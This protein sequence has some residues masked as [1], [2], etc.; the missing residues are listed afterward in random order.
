MRTLLKEDGSMDQDSGI[1]DGDKWV[2]TNFI[3]LVT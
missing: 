2:K 3:D 1:G